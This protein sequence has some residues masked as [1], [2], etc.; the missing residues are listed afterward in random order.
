MI[1][2]QLLPDYV[3]EGDKIRRNV[4]VCTVLLLLVT[5]VS[6]QWMRIW[7]NK[8]ADMKNQASVSGGF[9]QQIATLQGQIQTQRDMVAPFDNKRAYMTSL[10]DYG[11][12]YTEK[13]R[14]LGRYI[15][16]RVDVLSCT[17]NEGGFTMAVRTKTTEDVA[18][19]LMCL[20]AG[21][22]GGL[23]AQDSVT[24][25]GF[26]EGWPNATSP[27]GYSTSAFAHINL[28]FDVN[29]GGRS[30]VNSGATGMA[31]AR[32]ESAVAGV[33]ELPA[34]ARGLVLGPAQAARL[35]YIKPSADPPDQPYMNLTIDGKWA[36]PIVAPAGAAGAAGG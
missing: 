25:S 1:K 34:A 12:K 5:G 21:Y 7:Q 2:L 16:N 3:F 8:V 23:F 32:E 22:K 30:P 35:K 4:I 15:Y 20:K 31:Q 11:A 29:L 24:L 14:Q 18:R 10:C 33:G 27:S 6:V 19:T 9:Q 26:P 17:I 36:V 28:P 13:V